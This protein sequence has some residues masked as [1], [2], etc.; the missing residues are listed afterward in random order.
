MQ[1]KHRVDIITDWQVNPPE[2][3]IRTRCRSCDHVHFEGK[4]CMPDCKCTKPTSFTMRSDF[5]GWRKIKEHYTVLE[6]RK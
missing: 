1:Y 2:I 6:E 5:E 3:I 4:H